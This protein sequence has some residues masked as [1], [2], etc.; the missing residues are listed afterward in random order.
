MA[1]KEEM[2]ARRYSAAEL[3]KMALQS[4]NEARI[5]RG[6]PPVYNKGG[7]NMEDAAK[8]KE[9]EEKAEADKAKMLSQAKSLIDLGMEPK[10]VG[11]I[12]MGFGPNMQGGY[13]PPS[14]NGMGFD[15]VV[16]IIKLMDSRDGS[17]K[18]D[19][20]IERLERKIEQLDKRK[21]NK[22]DEP[23]DPMTYMMKQAEVVSGWRK[24]LLEMGVVVDPGAVRHDTKG[25]SIE[26]IK[27]RHR[28]DEKMEELKSEREYHA[29]M[30]EIAG[31]I[32]ERIG[33]GLGSQ[34]R[35]GNSTSSNS[36][37]KDELER[38]PCAD[39]G[40]MIYITPETQTRV[41]CPKCNMIFERDVA[42][43]IPI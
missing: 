25:E 8:K 13:T 28:H 29:R 5:L 17:S 42:A 36:N 33:R 30:T 16:K 38:F 43:E 6:E 24:T 27:E 11:A 12:L 40:T 20:A 15:D 9:E 4:E 23:I 26:S 19:A 3:E 39:C 32:P 2:A 7:T 10:Q 31:S 41:K 1:D 18:T 34:I 35:K 14:S 22:S 21:D 37:G